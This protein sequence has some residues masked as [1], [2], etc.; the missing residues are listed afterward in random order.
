MVPNRVALALQDDGWWVR[1]EI[2]WAKTTGLP[3]SVRDRPSVRHEKI[4]MLTKTARH[5]YDLEA[6]E[7]PS[8]D[9]L[10]MSV[11]KLSRG[12]GARGV[13]A[14]LN[15]GGRNDADM[16]AR[17][18]ARLMNGGAPTRRLR[19]YEDEA[20]LNVWRFAPAQFKDAHFATFPP[21]LVERC[22]AVGCPE[23][24]TVLDPFAGAGTTGLVADRL[25]YD[26]TLIELNPDYADLAVERIERE[27]PLTAEV[28]RETIQQG[29]L[30]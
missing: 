18:H 24:G 9:T 4:W 30:W 21:E 10:E 1:S 8:A 14:R 19:N 23:G 26:A 15:G 5:Y 22:L 3:E 2:V 13:S 25:G 20:H 17:E 16:F 28:S 11:K 12:N 27:A 6:G 29:M 7:V